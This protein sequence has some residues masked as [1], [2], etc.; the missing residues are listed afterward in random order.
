M[1]CSKSLRCDPRKCYAEDYGLKWINR[2]RMIRRE[3]DNKQINQ[4]NQRN[5]RYAPMVTRK[6]S[7]YFE[8]GFLLVGKCV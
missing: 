8:D 6:V 2:F 4:I 7:N 3:M 1:I 5:I